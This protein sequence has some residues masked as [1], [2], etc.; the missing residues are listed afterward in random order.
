MFNLKVL[1]YRQLLYEARASQTLKL[2]FVEITALDALLDDMR[3][4][5][6]EET[7]ILEIRYL[8]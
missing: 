3:D 1:H 7:Q 5:S 2:S 6:I 4:T 8:P